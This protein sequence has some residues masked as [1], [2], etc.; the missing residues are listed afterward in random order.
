[1]SYEPPLKTKFL[2]KEGKPPVRP[3][4]ENRQAE[5]KVRYKDALL[6]LQNHMRWQAGLRECVKWIQAVE[7]KKKKFFD[8]VMR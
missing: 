5:M 8:Y 2:I 4:Y 7:F 3:T 6:R 1:M